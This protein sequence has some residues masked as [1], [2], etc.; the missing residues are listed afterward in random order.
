MIT[1]QELHFYNKL[2]EKGLAP[3]LPCPINILDGNMIPWVDDEEV[4]CFWC[5]SCDTKSYLG[6]DQINFIKS[7]LH[8]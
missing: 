8:Q 6:I 3:P 1:I 4:P 2:S 7:T 5:L